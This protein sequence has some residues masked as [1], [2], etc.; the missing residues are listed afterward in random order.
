MYLINHNICFLSQ[1]CLKFFRIPN[2]QFAVLPRQPSRAADPLLCSLRGGGPHLCIGK[3]EVGTYIYSRTYTA[4]GALGALLWSFTA[5]YV[6]GASRSFSLAKEAS[7]AAFCSLP[8]PTLGLQHR[9]R[10]RPDTAVAPG[11]GRSLY[12]VAAV[13]LV[14]G[15]LEESSL[16]YSVCLVGSS[17]D[18]LRL[19]LRLSSVPGHAR[20][21]SGGVFAL[22]LVVIGRDVGLGWGAHHHRPQHQ[23]RG[24]VFAT[25]WLPW[26]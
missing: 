15:L 20:P 21:S 7:G 4:H 22:R 17:E 10:L 6:V 14:T 9:L 2:F 16:V 25:K 24:V 11:R 26:A 23:E 8:P 18:E 13:A 12:T 3:Q 5:A 19:R 1:K